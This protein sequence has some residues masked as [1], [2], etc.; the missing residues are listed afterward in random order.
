LKCLRRLIED[1]DKMHALNGLKY[2]STVVALAM[3]T[4]N[5]FRKGMVWKILAASSSSVATA[6][7]TY[8]DIVN[9]WGLLRKH[10]RNPW[11]RDKLSLQD[12]NL[13]FVAMVSFYFIANMCVL[14]II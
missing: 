2:T 10:S 3:R 13:Y 11:L 12:K 8:W 14:F 5:E 4:T 9:D 1:K 6:F 7:N